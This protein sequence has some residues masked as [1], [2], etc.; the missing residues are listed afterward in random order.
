MAISIERITTACIEKAL[1]AS[2]LQ[3]QAIASNIANANVKGYKVQRTNFEEQ[4]DVARSE[5]N[6]TG[7]AS[8]PT[9]AS[10]FPTIVSDESSSEENSGMKLDVEMAKLSENV[11]RYQTLLKGLNRHFSIMTTA[12]NE[13]KK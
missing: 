2:A 7:S 10:I 13:G 11:V 6:S 5:I 8:L 3:H 12:I 9:I 4:L 1:D